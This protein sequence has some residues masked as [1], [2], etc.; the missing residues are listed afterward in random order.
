VNLKSHKS[1]EKRKSTP[2]IAF[3]L[4]A[5]MAFSPIPSL[6]AHHV[7]NIASFTLSSL[8]TSVQANLTR[9]P[10]EV[11][12]WQPALIFAEVVGDFESIKL[13]V[14]ADVNLTINGNQPINLPPYSIRLP[15]LPWSSSRYVTAIP[16]LPAKTI[17]LTLLGKNATISSA[18]SYRLIVDDVEKTSGSY[19]VKEGVAELK[20][21][22]IAVTMVYN[23]LQDTELLKETM[24]LGPRGWVIGSDE[25]LKTLI[26]A[27]DDKGLSEVSFEYSVSGRTWVTVSPNQDPLMGTLMSFVDTVNN[28]I[29]QIRNVVPIFPDLAVHLPLGIYNATIPGQAVGNYVKFRANATDVDGNSFTSPMG[30]YYVVNKAGPT[31]VL[32][33]DPHVKLWLLQKN[34]ELLLKILKQHSSYNLP[35]DFTGNMTLTARVS[36]ALEKHGIVPFHHW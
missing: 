24:G 9:V 18:V 13:N 3:V 34:V 33:V 4:I 26:V 17:E 15:L 8:S 27:F 20:K 23:V 25:D 32:I 19:I 11:Y 2:F 21:P 5:I 6:R 14:T 1:R 12:G 31:R 22:P 36:E 29:E 35:V 28:I 30:F 7:N 10:E 16:G